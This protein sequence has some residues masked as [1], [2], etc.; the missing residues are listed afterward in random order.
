M[1]AMFW[2]AWS[3]ARPT[4]MPHWIASRM[5][6]GFPRYSAGTMLDFASC[7]A[8]SKASAKV[9]GTSERRT[10]EGSCRS[11]AISFGICSLHRRLHAEDADVLRRDQGFLAVLRRVGE[12]P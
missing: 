2:I 5:F 10:V 4:S 6:S 11:V 12:R 7:V 9:V 1:T 8:N 3:G